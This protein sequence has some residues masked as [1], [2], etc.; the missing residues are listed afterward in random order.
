MHGCNRNAWGRNLEDANAVCR[1]DGVSTTE[2]SPECLQQ[3]L[4]LLSCTRRV[5]AAAINAAVMYSRQRCSDVR[6]CLARG[7]DVRAAPLVPH[8]RSDA[9]CFLAR[10][11]DAR[12]CLTRAAMHAASSLAAAMHVASSLAAAMHVA[13]SLAAAMHAV[14]VKVSIAPA[15]ARCKVS[16][17]NRLGP[18]RHVT[19]WTVAPCNGLD[20]CTM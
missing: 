3:R 8:S 14:K 12:C 6:C 15:V 9:R 7:I 11:S 1:C 10:G 4:T 13:S 20:R 17:P 18:L 5:L 19:A 2:V 16:S